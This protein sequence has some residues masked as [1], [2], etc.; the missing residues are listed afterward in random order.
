MKFINADLLASV[1]GTYDQTRTTIQGRILQ[2]TLSGK[3]CLGPSLNKFIDIIT[4]TVGQTAINVFISDNG[5][6]FTINTETGGLIQCFLHTIDFTTGSLAYIGRIQFAVAD[7]AATTHTYRGLKVIDNGNTGWKI[8]LATTGSILI[9]GGLYMVNNINL[10]DFAP[11]GFPTI[12]FATGTNQKAV[13]FLQDPASIGV[14]QL[15]TTTVGFILDKTQNRI[16]A[17]NGVSATHQYYVYD[18]IATPTYSTAPVTGVAATDI[19][20]HAGHT[21]LDNDPIVF[22]SITG[23]AG[24]TAGTTYFVRNPVAGVSYQISATSGGAV[25]NFTTDISAGQVGRAFG[26]TGSNWLFKTGNLP[27]LTGTL[28]GNDNEYFAVPGHT[29]NAGQDCVFFATTSNLYLGRISDLTAG[30]TIWPSLVTSNLLGAPNQIV[31]PSAVFTAWSTALDRAIY[32]THSNVFVM[33]QV[34]NNSIDAI[35]GGNTNKYFEGFTNDIVEYQMNAINGISLE[36]GGWLATLGSVN[37]AGQRG[38]FLTD[39]RSDARFDYSFIVTKVLDT[40][41]S[42]YK[43]ITTLNKYLESTGDLKVY[44]RT[45]GFGVISGGW[46]S[47]PLAED[48]SA[49]TSGTQV[50]FKILFDTLRLGASIPAQIYEFILGLQD[51]NEISSNWEYNHDDTNPATNQVVYRL[52]KAYSGSVPNLRHTVRDL[53]DTLVANHTTVANSSFFEYSIDN[54]A[55]WL[56]LGT[57]PNTVGTLLRYTNNSLPAQELRPVIQEA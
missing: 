10:T 11:L 35:F 6:I 34:V 53:S 26:T 49:F 19:I 56:T 44:Y 38:V 45:S 43:F 32:I 2:K 57:I 30:I 46:V 7:V 52:K 48:L 24:I 33:K 22:T 17:H 1:G 5:R 55:N 27:V 40:P 37:I 9:N 41:A 47:L 8:F 25:L 29:S 28:L 21:F 16:Y 3:S 13:Y 51:L 12:P 39:L 42:I 18:A 36:Q 4:D 23:G 14:G 20:S 31:A 15:Q 50:Q 54:G